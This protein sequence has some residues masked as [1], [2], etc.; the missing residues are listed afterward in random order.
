MI[1]QI[2]ILGL[3]RQ[4]FTQYSMCCL[5]LLLM[6]SDSMKVRIQCEFTSVQLIKDIL[7]ALYEECNE[8]R[9]DPNLEGQR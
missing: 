4:T 8:L 7:K 6:V 1:I 5:A 2:T 9:V 3:G